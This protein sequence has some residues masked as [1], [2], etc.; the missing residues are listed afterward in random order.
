[1]ILA[2]DPGKDK[3]GLA[4]LDADGH[5]LEKAVFARK[6]LSKIIPRY[7]H[8]YTL[9]FLVVGQT[10]TG[11]EVEQELS[12]LDLRVNII[13]VSEKNSTLEARKLYWRLNRPRGLWLLIPTSFRTPPVPIDDY[14]AVI[15]GLR[16]L[17]KM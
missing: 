10:A 15:I 4:V 14:A 17:N 9:T 16:F 5:V 13:F 2:L 8:Q 1:M 6:D 3:C 12:R 7:P 11:K